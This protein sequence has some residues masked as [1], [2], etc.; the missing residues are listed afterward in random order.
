MTPM[1]ANGGSAHEGAGGAGRLPAE[2]RWCGGA[3]ALQCLVLVG[4]FLAAPREWLV[5]DNRIATYPVYHEMGRQLRGGSFPLLSEYS[6]QAAG[7]AGEYG[8][9]CFHPPTLLFAALVSTAT[10]PPEWLSLGWIVLWYGVLLTGVYVLARSLAAPPPLAAYAA[11]AAGAS[12]YLLGLAPA[13]WIVLHSAAWLP[14][15][16]WTLRQACLAETWRPR[17]GWTAAAGI[18]LA[19]VITAGWNFSDVAALVL[20]AHVAAE[21]VLR[22]RSARPLVPAVA[23][24]LSGL[25]LSAPAWMTHLEYARWSY[26]A[27][28]KIDLATPNG[29]WLGPL[30]WLGLVV[31]VADGQGSLV[32]GPLLGVG[33]IPLLVVL[34]ALV[35]DRGVVR[36]HAGLFLLAA[37]AAVLCGLPDLPPLRWMFRFHPLFG[38]V[39]AILSAALL[40][41]VLEQL[42][43]RDAAARRTV[44][45]CAIAC[46]VA[47][48]AGVL[49]PHRRPPGVAPVIAWGA[50]VTTA[51]WVGLAG[52]RRRAAAVL[53]ILALAVTASARLLYGQPW[54]AVFEAP[55][56][57]RDRGCAVQ[58]GWYLCN[59]DQATYLGRQRLSAFM[60]GNMAMESGLRTVNGY[61]TML[62]CGPLLVFGITNQGFVFDSRRP[63]AGV[64]DGRGLLARMAV[65]GLI[66]RDDV[67]VDDPV[68]ADFER[69]C[70]LDGFQI[71]HRRGGGSRRVQAHHA[72]R[73]VDSLEAAVAALTAGASTE[74]L[75]ERS[76]ERATEPAA[77]SAAD[78]GQPAAPRSVAFDLPRA[79][80]PAAEWPAA[81][82]V[83]VDVPAAGAAALVSFARPWLP[84]YRATLDGEPLDVLRMDALMPAVVVPAGGRGRLELRYFPESL[85]RGLAIAAAAAAVHVALAA[86][87][88]ATA[89]YP[90]P[91]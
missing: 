3:V 57:A 18:V 41:E 62:P 70:D 90:R 32:A 65:D 29:A 33:T 42:G 54:G 44:A 19:L 87:L 31:P 72:A 56:T 74:P 85:R 58:P 46:G 2:C 26:R 84:G 4:L 91:T 22:T 6:W 77:A 38:L 34:A 10:L 52:D 11:L 47:L 78:E 39:L 45:W 68:I 9:G 50:L 17:L 16:W 59:Y 76:T 73:Q 66:L 35:L 13:W 21:A 15:Y 67:A 55:R 27:I 30:D 48:V 89:W 82:V 7:I 49:V 75:I 37:V 71:W 51:G 24:G 36:R 43:R 53:G 83:D 20:H 25:A 69:A 81:V 1:H 61:S 86:A 60:P 40:P 79:L 28:A 64:S 88:A 80:E 8:A 5:D 63:C 23:A 12:G 14:W